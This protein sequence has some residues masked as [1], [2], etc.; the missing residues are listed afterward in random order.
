MREFNTTL[1]NGTNRIYARLIDPTDGHTVYSGDVY[2]M[3]GSALPATNKTLR[4][5]YSGS[6]CASHMCSIAEGGN[7]VV[8]A[9]SENRFAIYGGG[10]IGSDTSVYSTKIF[11]TNPAMDV[12]GVVDDLEDDEFLDRVNPMFGYK[13]GSSD[14]VITAE[15]RPINTYIS[16]SN[17]LNPG[18]RTLVFRNNGLT[19]EGKVNITVTII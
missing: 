9:A 15:L 2:V 12:S 10:S 19:A 4:V 6:S 3:L 8:G 14:Y 11:A 7:M 1:E 18:K 13:K 17:S 5:S 16:G